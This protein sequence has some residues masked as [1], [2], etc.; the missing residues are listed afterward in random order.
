MEQRD[1]I[2]KRVSAVCWIMDLKSNT[3]TWLPFTVPRVN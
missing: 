1:F 3:S 2:S